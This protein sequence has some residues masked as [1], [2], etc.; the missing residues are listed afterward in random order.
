M[1]ILW[2][3]LARAGAVGTIAAVIVNLVIFGL[4]S[5]ADVSWET[6]DIDPNA[7]AVALS[8]V[9]AGVLATILAM[10]LLHYLKVARPVLVFLV[11]GVAFTLLSLT[12]PLNAE[13]DT[14]TRWLLASMHVVAGVLILG[15][16]AWMLNAT[17]KPSA[18]AG[19]ERAADASRQAPDEH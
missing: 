9:L 15:S 14:S 8:T 13:A 19:G 17:R 10:V 18:T 3:P 5:A 2:S 12:A 7:G 16:L 11:I 1:G 6:G 4:G